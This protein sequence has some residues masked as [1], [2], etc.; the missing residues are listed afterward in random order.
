MPFFWTTAL[1]TGLAGSLHCVLMCG[2]LAGA[3]PTGRLSAAGTAGARA[4]YHAG[5][6]GTYAALGALAGTLGQGALAVLGSSGYLS[7]ASGAVLLVL[8][9][10]PNSA[11]SGYDRVLARLRRVAGPYLRQPSVGA[12]FGMGMLNGL[13]PCGL[14]SVAL[15]GALATGSTAGGSTFGLVFGLGTIPTLLAVQLGAE[16]LRGVLPAGWRTGLYRAMAVLLL[17]RGL[18][19]G[20]PYLSPASAAAQGQAGAP[21]PVCHDVP[22]G[23]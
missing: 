22:P 1:L 5:R 23:R 14:V 20:I 18:Q 15:A 17:L 11:N 3:L 16:G 4:L 8:T 12:F 7:L 10:R 6:V 2:P 21:I 13:L 19:L 9:L